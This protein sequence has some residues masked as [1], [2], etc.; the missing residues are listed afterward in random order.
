MT[1]IETLDPTRTV[2][3]LV[4]D[5]PTRA[6]VF[7]RFGLDYCCHGQRRLADACATAAVSVTNVVSALTVS[8]AER[9]TTSIP[10][11][12]D[13]LADHIETTH[14]A[15]LHEELPALVALAR[16]VHDVHGARHPE[17]IA[18]ERLVTR[19]DADLGP[20]LAAEE[21]VVFPA[22]RTKPITPIDFDSAI[23]TLR[24]EHD[25]LGD[26]LAEL[27]A[28]TGGYRAPADGCASYQALY[29]RLAQLESDTHLH[30]HLENN[31]LFP[32]ITNGVAQ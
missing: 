8:E 32:A 18:V 28:I 6:A 16:K 19:L 5:D 4:T 23:D 26:L 2:A 14:H 20:H 15:Y 12:L 29:A 9:A 30:I 13:Q 22:L 24:D 10:T 27:K 31:V 3:D 1:I 25:A 11:D 7:D 21:L 17:L